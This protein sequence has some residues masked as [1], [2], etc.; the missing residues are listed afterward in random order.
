MAKY[1]IEW[2]SEA[3]LDLLSILDFYYQRNGNTSFS[4]KLYSKIRK[5]LILISKNPK[6][7]LRTDIETVRVVVMGDYQIVYEII[8]T[9]ILIV[10]FWDCRRNP[11]DKIVALQRKR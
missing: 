8:E 3:R 11:E 2:T 10:L 1:K 5:K 7:G 9:T 4:R 6:S